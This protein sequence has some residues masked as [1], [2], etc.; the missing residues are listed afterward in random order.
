M[1]TPYLRTARAGGAELP[2]LDALD[3][4]AEVARA[5]GSAGWCLMPV[6]APSRTSAPLLTAAPGR[7]STSTDTALPGV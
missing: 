4:F 1:A 7:R 3:V 5:D 2:L 6:P